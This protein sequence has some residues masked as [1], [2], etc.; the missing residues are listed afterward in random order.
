MKQLPILLM[1][2][3]IAMLMA[4]VMQAQSLP[5]APQPNLSD[6]YDWSRLERL[7][8]YSQIS[9]ISDRRRTIHCQ[10]VGVDD[11]GLS[12]SFQSFWMPSYSFDF[13]RADIEEV[14]LRHE[15]RDFWIG[16]A[17]F[18][19]AGFAVGATGPGATDSGSRVGRGIVGAGLGGLMAPIFVYPVVHLL[20]GKTIYRR[21]PHLRN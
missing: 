10:N 6:T 8:S 17:V 2:I 11:R 13:A 16:V 12:C 21:P 1:L 5:S 9:V 19:A 15:R 4:R 18:S 14:R 7:D 3:V 20:P